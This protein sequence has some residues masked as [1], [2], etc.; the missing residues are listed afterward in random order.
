[1]T[2]W[3]TAPVGT[4]SLELSP[5]T[6]LPVAGRE[7]SRDARPAEIAPPSANT[8]TLA[9][10]DQRERRQVSP[11]RTNPSLSN[12]KGRKPPPTDNTLPWRI[13][14]SLVLN[15][16]LYG[17]YLLW[18]RGS[19][20]QEPPVQEATRQEDNGKRAGH[21]GKPLAIKTAEG[22]DPSTLKMASEIQPIGFRHQRKYDP[23]ASAP[24][25]ILDFG[26]DPQ[27]ETARLPDSD[28]AA[29][30]ADGSPPRT[31]DVEIRLKGDASRHPAPRSG[32]SQITAEPPRP[33]LRFAGPLGEHFT[34]Y[35]GES[36][37]GE[38]PFSVP[39]H[40]DGIVAVTNYRLI[41][42]TRRTRYSLMPPFVRSEHR[43]SRIKLL[44]VT[45]M[46]ETRIQ[47][48]IFLVVAGLASWWLP[49]GILPAAF[50]MVA[51]FYMTRSETGVRF[52]EDWVRSWPL[53]PESADDFREQTERATAVL[54]EAV[55]RQRAARKNQMPHSA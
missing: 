1:M 27:D 39:L 52:E 5:S 40:S 36:I 54:K 31:A 23:D 12:R 10:A 9:E 17:I 6:T 19:A 42:L 24:D 34:A 15:F 25:L 21:V 55:R 46:E 20:L 22:V 44:S 16:G 51:F 13:A 48:P 29:R 50:A 45:E 32:A 49:F 3:L 35:R 2:F 26:E 33:T 28:S 37:L 8:P 47:R 38:Y 30:M 14:T 4:V 11:R 41:A 43:R 53:S 7:V 18:R